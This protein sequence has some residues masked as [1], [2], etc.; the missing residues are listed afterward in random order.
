MTVPPLPPGDVARHLWFVATPARWPAWPF[1]PVIRCAG[2]VI[3]LGLMFDARAAC[4]LTGYSA[5]VFRCCLF[6]LP[7]TVAAFLALPREVFDTGEE[8]IR[9]GWRVD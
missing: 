5:T 6:D 7:P 3:D 2:G 9:A 8:L 4:G 1:L